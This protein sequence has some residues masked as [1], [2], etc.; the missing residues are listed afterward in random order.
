M[1]SCLRRGL[2]NGSGHND[3]GGGSHGSGVGV[4]RGLCV[5]GVRNFK[6]ICLRWEITDMCIRDPV[7]AYVLADNGI[8][9]GPEE[10]PNN[11]LKLLH[12]VICSS[13]KPF[14]L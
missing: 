2:L 5:G 6:T 8:R 3:G 7:R 1:D 12:T 13:Q 11:L 10:P 14:S 9:R 4:L